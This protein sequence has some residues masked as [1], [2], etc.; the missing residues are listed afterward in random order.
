MN[1][2]IT[3]CNNLIYLLV[4]FFYSFNSFAPIFFID[5]ICIQSYICFNYKFVFDAQTKKVQHDA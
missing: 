5:Q 3:F 2:T 4:L 1:N